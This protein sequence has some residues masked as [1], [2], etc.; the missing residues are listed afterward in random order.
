MAISHTFSVE[1][2]VSMR[3]PPD[4][5]TFPESEGLCIDTSFGVVGC[6]VDALIRRE[7][8]RGAGDVIATDLGFCAL[9]PLNAT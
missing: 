6:R 7:K 3:R 8:L 9:T 4:H 1:T 5:V 2:A